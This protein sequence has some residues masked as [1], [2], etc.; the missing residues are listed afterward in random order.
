MCRAARSPLGDRSP[1]FAPLGMSATL[2]KLGFASIRSR[3][4]A[5]ALTI[6]IASGATAT[7]ILALEVGATARD[8]WQRTFKAANGAHVL[9]TVPSQADA[10]AIAAL[11]ASAERDE[12][13]PSAFAT[14]ADGGEDRLQLAGLAAR[15]GSTRRCRRRTRGRATAAS[16]WSAASPTRSACESAHRS[17]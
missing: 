4:L 6:L 8:P 10:R 5:S 2:V 12:P 11:P 9:A 7:I 13:V 14:V 1:A 3:L 15:R 17:T 16:C